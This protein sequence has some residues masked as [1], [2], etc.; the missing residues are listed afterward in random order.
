[1][2]APAKSALDARL[3]NPIVSAT[4]DVLETMAFTKASL[5]E[6]KPQKGYSPS[7]DIS[8]IIGITGED[9]DGTV[10]LSFNTPL[11][12]VLVSRLLGSDSPDSV[13]ADDRCDGIGELI[14]M[15][16]GNAKTSL[17]KGNGNPYRLSL[18]TIIMGVGHEVANRN[19]G[20]YLAMVFETE[21]DTFTLQVTFKANEG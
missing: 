16:S 13:T 11:A 3:V 9:G 10:T 14:N 21:G 1:M 20:P 18:P 15:I 19:A 12:N 4:V 7:G 8:A 6:V 2:T 17:A 5:K